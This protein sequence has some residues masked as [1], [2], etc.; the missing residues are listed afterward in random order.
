MMS[1]EASTVGVSIFPQHGSDMDTLV[2]NAEAA[3]YRAKTEQRGTIRCFEP[4]MDR[5]T[6]EKRALQQEIAVATERNE[7]ELYFQPQAVTGGEVFGFEVLVRWRHPVRGMVSSRDIHSTGGRDRL[8]RT[9]R[10]MGVARGLPGS[11]LVGQS[12]FDRS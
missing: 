12:A 6:R 7:L 8:D 2:A 9:D 10:R 11:G 4:A 3:L 5:H 1:T